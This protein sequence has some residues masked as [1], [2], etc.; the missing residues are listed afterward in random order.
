[1]GG[2]AWH[3]AAAADGSR[4][5]HR[6]GAQ[7]DDEALAIARRAYPKWQASLTH[8]ARMHNVPTQNPRPPDFDA[9]R[10]GG[11]GIAGSPATVAAELR[12]QLV[13][14]GANYCVGQFAFGDMT[15]A[16]VTRTIDLFAREV[17][18]ALA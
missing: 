10:H 18:P 8:L 17:M 6:G 13:E 4:A 16:E 14:A 7:T 2:D 3:Q 1:M 9:I 11:R 12:K 15:L 5:L